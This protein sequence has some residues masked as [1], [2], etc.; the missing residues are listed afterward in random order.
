VKKQS[1]V[2]FKDV[3][4]VTRGRCYDRNF[5]RFLTLFGEKIGVFLKN[6]CYDQNFSKFSFVSSQKAQ[7][8]RKNF[9][10]KYFKIITSVPNFGEIFTKKYLR[11]LGLYYCSHCAHLCTPMLA[12]GDDTTQST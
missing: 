1:N 9:R 7:F 2:S 11:K 12:S 3:S 10:R 4:S 8:F 5:L 6:Q